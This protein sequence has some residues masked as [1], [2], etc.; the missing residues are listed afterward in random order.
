MLELDQRFEWIGG[1]HPFKQSSPSELPSLADQLSALAAPGCE[2]RLLFTQPLVGP[3]AALLQLQQ[4][5]PDL[6]PLL[7]KAEQL[8]RSDLAQAPDPAALEQATQRA[9]L[10]VALEAMGGIP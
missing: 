5:P 1:R 2:L 10:A 4:L 9:R 8:E 3:A 6:Q 7:Q